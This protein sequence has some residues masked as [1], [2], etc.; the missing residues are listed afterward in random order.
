[1]DSIDKE[2]SENKYFI[3]LS[4]KDNRDLPCA[5]LFTY[6]EP[7]QSNPIKPEGCRESL[8]CPVNVDPYYESH[9]EWEGAGGE[10]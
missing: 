8:L 5:I 6:T 1:M 9:V 3:I 2:I 7:S 4:P 10:H